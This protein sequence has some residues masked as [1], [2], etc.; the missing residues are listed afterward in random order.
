[1]PTLRA[2]KQTCWRSAMGGK[3][4]YGRRVPQQ[5]TS[6]PMAALAHSE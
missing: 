3:E 1:M 5:P 6:A 4:T 2:E